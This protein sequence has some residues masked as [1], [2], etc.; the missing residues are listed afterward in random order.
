ML[1]AEGA[2]IEDAVVLP[3]ASIGRGATVP[4]HHRQALRAADGF[5]VGVDP[6]RDRE[7]FHVTE[8]GICLVTPG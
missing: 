8:R 6:A 4:G 2:L 1:V 7:R 5:T 3:S